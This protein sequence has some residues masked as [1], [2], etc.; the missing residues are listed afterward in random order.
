ME[1]R[2][3]HSADWQIGMPAQFMSGEASARYSESRLD[4]IRRIGRVA[5]ERDC[6]FVVVA[7]DVFDANL[8]SRRTILRAAEAMAEM[9]MPV[10]LLPGNHDPLD[11]S[12]IY[13]NQDLVAHLPPHVHVIRDGDPV[14]VRPGVEVVG[15]LWRTKRPTEDLL[16]ATIRDLPA[17]GT[18]RVAVGHGAVDD[19]MG[20]VRDEPST[21]HLAAVE[22]A[23]AE[24]RHPRRHRRLKRRGRDSTNA[25]RPRRCARRRLNSMRAFITRELI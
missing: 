17:D 7:G 5:H 10:Y 9:P 23:I 15:A 19:V 2:F 3:L 12:T 8:I 1:V 20:A 14:V 16:S 18:V 24:P 25:R 21:I 11:P 4:A 22:N 6:E 13:D